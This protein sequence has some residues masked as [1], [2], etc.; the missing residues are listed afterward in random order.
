MGGG[1]RHIHRDVPQPSQLRATGPELLT[2]IPVGG[3]RWG[4]GGGCVDSG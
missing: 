3:P 1:L 2:G 4:G